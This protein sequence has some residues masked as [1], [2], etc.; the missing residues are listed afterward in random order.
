MRS[1]V[2]SEERTET[3]DR[4]QQGGLRSTEASRDGGHEQDHPSRYSDDECQQRSEENGG[5]QM[6]PTEVSH[7][8]QRPTD[9]NS[10]KLANFCEHSYIR[11]GFRVDIAC[12]ICQRENSHKLRSCCAIIRRIR[13]ACLRRQSRECDGSHLW[14]VVNA[15]SWPPPVGLQQQPL[16]LGV[17]RIRHLLGLYRHL[18]LLAG[19][20]RVH[21]QH[22]QVGFRHALIHEPPARHSVPEGPHSYTNLLPDTVYLRDPA[23]TRTSCQTQCT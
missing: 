11:I 6:T 23:H 22:Q 12:C 20:E 17:G 15:F 4:V 14:V 5:G 19:A 21:H 3:G 16:A 2:N 9:T 18:H 7:R 13:E 10:Q 8:L 1:Q